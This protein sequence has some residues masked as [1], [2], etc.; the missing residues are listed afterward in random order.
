MLYCWLCSQVIEDINYSTLGATTKGFSSNQH[1]NSVFGKCSFE[2]DAISGV[3]SEVHPDHP[4]EYEDRLKGYSDEDPFIQHPD[5]NSVQEQ[6]SL[7]NYAFGKDPAELVWF[8]EKSWS[9]N[10]GYRTDYL[11]SDTR[12][13]ASTQMDQP[14]EETKQSNTALEVNAEISYTDSDDVVT[15]D[16]FQFSPF[17]AGTTAELASS[18]KKKNMETDAEIQQSANDIFETEMSFQKVALRG[19]KKAFSMK[20]L[21]I[22]V[23][24]D[25]SDTEAEIKKQHDVS[26]ISEYESLSPL[27]VNSQIHATKPL[28]ARTGHRGE[29]VS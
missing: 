14:F 18:N 2:T 4:F 23:I 27:T 5:L 3:S 8:R 22:N 11:F 25:E 9:T 13:E 12:F 21:N 6:Q 15:S 28:S 29:Q 17:T 26:D 7:N 24:E 19:Q 20:E 16:L 10:A 1:Q